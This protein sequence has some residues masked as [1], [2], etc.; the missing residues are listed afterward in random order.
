[1]RSTYTLAVLP[2]ERHADCAAEGLNEAQRLH[3]FLAQIAREAEVADALLDS[4]QDELGMQ[5]GNSECCLLAGTRAAMDRIKALAA[6]DDPSAADDEQRRQHASDL[7][8]DC[9]SAIIQLSEDA[10]V[11]AVVLRA[12]IERT[13]G[14]IGASFSIRMLGSLDAV[15]RILTIAAFPTDRASDGEAGR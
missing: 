5:L 3:S 2:E 8:D 11:A 7:S 1:M 6:V 4:M 14:T 10:E 12:L 15:R 13:A 9:E